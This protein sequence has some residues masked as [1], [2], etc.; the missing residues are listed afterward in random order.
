MKNKEEFLKKLSKIIDELE[1][2]D[3]V[4]DY[5][6]MSFSNYNPDNRKNEK[7]LSFFQASIDYKFDTEEFYIQD[8]SEPF[9]C[10]IGCKFCEERGWCNGDC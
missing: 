3:A 4:L 6:T 8:L 2:K 9:V 1:D 7:K 5:F 10:T